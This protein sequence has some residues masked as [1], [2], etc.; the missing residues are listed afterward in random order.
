MQLSVS[1]KSS[2]RTYQQAEPRIV[3]M[4]ER[5]LRYQLDLDGLDAL[6]SLH[7]AGVVFLKQA[8]RCEEVR[9]IVKTWSKL[10]PGSCAQQG[11][12]KTTWF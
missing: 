9:Y 11:K 10:E 6:T 3:Q 8:S 5:N 4:E 12:W 1:L 7:N 2:P